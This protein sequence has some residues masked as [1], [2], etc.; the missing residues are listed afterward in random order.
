MAKAVEAVFRVEERHAPLPS[1][2]AYRARFHVVLILRQL[3]AK[4]GQLL[5]HSLPGRL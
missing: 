2:V 3:D 5:S 4:L 1:T